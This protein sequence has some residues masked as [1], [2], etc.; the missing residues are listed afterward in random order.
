MYINYSI[1]NGKEYG[2]LTTSDRK[3]KSVSKGEQI[4]FRRVV[5]KVNGIFKSRERGLFKY[6]IV[7]NMYSHVPADFEE[8]KEQRKTSYSK[9]PVLIV[10]F[11]DIYLLDSFMSES[12]IMSAINDINYK[13]QDTLHAL[14]ASY[15]LT[16]YSNCHVEDWWELT[17]A[18]YLYPKAQMTS[19]RISEAL[20]DIGSEDA[21]RGFFKEYFKFLAKRKGADD[22]NGIVDGILIDNSGLPNS[23]CFH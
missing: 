16:T 10:S 21:K 7:T 6:D 2:T 9:R 18:K 8:P 3:R 13:N 14:T 1:V 12:G 19:Q 20:A 22:S 5:D 11:G 15:I 4:Y 23:V 17:Y